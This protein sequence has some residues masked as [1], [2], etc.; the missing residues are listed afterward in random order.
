MTAPETSDSSHPIRAVSFDLDGTLYA[1]GPHRLRLMPRLLPQ[2]GLI[3]AWSAAVRSL[4]DTE[5][6]ELSE[7]IVAETASRL[8]A[9][10]E[11]TRARLWFFLE[12]TWIPGL[13]PAHVLPGVLDALTLLDARGIPRLVASDHPVEAKLTR[14][15]LAEGWRAGL[16]AEA[17]GAL[18]PHPE[19]LL[20]AAR[21]VDQPPACLLHIGD[22]RDTDGEAARAAGARYLHA[23]DERGSTAS[24]PM[25][26]AAVLDASTAPESS[27]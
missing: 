8:G 18:K 7:R 24:L 6:P 23:L 11:E 4:R 22:R 17:L 1:T 16:C 13:E 21:A 20:A 27:P 5:E 26:L 14:L 25:R 9:P 3:R 10:V 12:R 2:L 15:G 19:I